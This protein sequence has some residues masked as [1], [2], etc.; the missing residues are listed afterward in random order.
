MFDPHSTRFSRWLAPLV[1]AVVVPLLVARA[2][3]K[4]NAAPDLD[5]NLLLVVGA[6]A[7][8]GIGLLVLLLDPSSPTIEDENETSALSTI[9]SNGTLVSRFLAVAGAVVFFAAPVSLILSAV[10]VVMNRDVSGWPRTMSWVGLVLST[11]ATILFATVLIF[12]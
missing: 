1:G 10:A 9:E 5:P 11:L 3:N 8:F 2:F 12:S 7:G 4:P 6:A